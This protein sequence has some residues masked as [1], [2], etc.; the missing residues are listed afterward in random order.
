MTNLSNTSRLQA[1]MGDL[2]PEGRE[3]EPWPVHPR[4]VLRQ[5]T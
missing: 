5:N 4:C 2:G 3:F 1:V